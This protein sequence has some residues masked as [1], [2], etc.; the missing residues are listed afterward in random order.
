MCVSECV[1]W[2]EAIFLSPPCTPVSEE[3]GSERGRGR[4]TRRDLPL[5]CVCLPAR[6]GLRFAS[7]VEADREL[8]VPHNYIHH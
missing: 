1:R 7:V 4:G 2:G 3:A 8:Q 5:L 6:E